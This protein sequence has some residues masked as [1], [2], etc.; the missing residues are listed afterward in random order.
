LRG[1]INK[2]GEILTKS[3]HALI[4]A[5]LCIIVWS[6]MPLVSKLANESIGLLSFLLLSNL[7]SAGVILAYVGTA[8]IKGFRAEFKKTA[9]KTMPLGFL[10]GFFFYLCLYYA[11]SKANGITVLVAQYLW[12][13]LIVLLSV[14][15]LN[16]RL[17]F[18]KGVACG[19]GFL[20][21]VV[22]VSK[23]NFSQ[24]EAGN[25]QAVAV[26]V[27]G[28][29]AFAAFSVFS[30]KLA[31][32]PLI[33]TLQCFIWASLFSF[34]ALVLFGK[35]ELPRTGA[36]WAVV[37]VNGAVINGLSYVWWLKALALEEASKIAPLVFLTPI[38]A[39]VWLVLF[40]NE[41]FL[42]VYAVGIVACI[43]S[44]LLASKK[45]TIPRYHT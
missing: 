17:N 35:F 43:A 41:A 7:L 36:G 15:F 25:L 27:V 29:L 11:Y 44:G 10:G 16:E 8:P 31:A 26:A 39:C 37:I 3:K 19:L 40:F 1:I 32:N 30:K 6:F 4:L 9:F 20:G 14:L 13:I 34:T 42:P 33:S 22:V 24:L 2:Y 18:H 21:V 28:A 23:G 12:P 5:L 45:D 38:L